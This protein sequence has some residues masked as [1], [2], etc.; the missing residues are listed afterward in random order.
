[1]LLCGAGPSMD[2]AVG[3]IYLRGKILYFYRI[4]P[5][6]YVRADEYCTSAY[7]EWTC[8]VLVSL[9]RVYLETLLVSTIQ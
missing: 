8:A 4:A 9:Y 6:F 5:D 1:M 3:L 2:E 7:R